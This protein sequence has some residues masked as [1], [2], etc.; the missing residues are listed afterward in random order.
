MQSDD[1]ISVIMGVYYHR[2]TIDLLERAIQSI[3]QQTYGN[4]ELLI[5]DDGSTVAAMKYIEDCAAQDKRIRLVRGVAQTDL[6]TKLNACIRASKGKYIA[7]M[8]DDD[9]SYPNRFSVQLEYLH[10]H[11]G[12]SFVGCNVEIRPLPM[13]K[14]AGIKEFPENPT[15]QDF[16]MTQPF[17]HPSLMFRREAMQAVGGYGED[18]HQR[19]CEDYDLLLRMYTTGLCGVNLQQALLAYSIPATTKGNRKMKHR[20]NE[21]CTRWCRFRDLNLLPWALPYVIKPIVVGCIPEIILKRI[22]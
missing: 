17:I 14:Y 19:L 5:A 4:F 11:P 1:L 21:V 2:D 22:K 10:T 13:L 16:Y 9:Y 18:K 3:L 7:R 8:D 15:I 12:I 6:A 20:W